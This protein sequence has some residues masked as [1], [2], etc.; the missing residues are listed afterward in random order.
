[1][2]NYFVG[3]DIAK[4]VHYAVILNNSQE[5]II[6]AFS[7]QNNI[8]GFEKLKSI[9]SDYPNIL[10]V[11]ESTGNFHYNLFHYLN[12]LDLN[13][14]L[15][16][17]VGVS[18]F[19]KMIHQSNKTDPLDSI[20]IA[21]YAATMGIEP[22]YYN[23]KDLQELRDI[24]RLKR[25]YTEDISSIKNRIKSLLQLCFPEYSKQFSNVYGKAPLALLKAYPTAEKLKFAR[26]S[27]VTKIVRENSRGR[28]DIQKAEALISI[29]KNSSAS[30]FGDTYETMMTSLLSSLESIQLL[31]TQLDHRIEL[32]MSEL[33][34]Y[35][36]TIPGIGTTL[37]A[38]ILAEIGDA[39]RFSSPS[40]IISYAGMH[41]SAKQSGYSDTSNNQRITKHGN[42]HLRRSLYMAAEKAAISDPELKLYYEKKK[43]EGKH[44]RVV[45]IGIARKL[46][47]RIYSILINHR[48][49]EIRSVDTE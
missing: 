42:S 45:V 48:P 39:K 38:E 18:N 33:N 5:I 22:T 9:C 49:Y 15:A 28:Y 3:I 26:L 24:T 30:C 12:H 1:M 46:T 17:T 31:I 14:A 47:N 16:S 36:E 35:L 41:S 29:A 37:A 34:C 11:M 20:L 8:V 40:Q 21:K 6:P 23:P 27:K 32:L 7:F 10:F 4:D 44:H 19:R 2:Y 13:V 25:S 43:Q